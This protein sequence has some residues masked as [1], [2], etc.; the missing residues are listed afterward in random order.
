MAV[1]HSFTF[2]PAGQPPRRQ[3][4]RSASIKLLTAEDDTQRL[5]IWIETTRPGETPDD[6]GVAGWDSPVLVNLNPRLS[7]LPGVGEAPVE[8][9]EAGQADPWRDDF[10]YYW[11]HT[12]YVAGK[13]TI[14]SGTGGCDITFAGTCELGNQVSFSASFAG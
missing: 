13:M 14:A 1:V 4:I 9:P 6:R 10:L 11:E 5:A 12:S 7:R 8:F 3:E 2:T